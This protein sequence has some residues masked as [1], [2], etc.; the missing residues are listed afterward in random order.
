MRSVHDRQERREAFNRENPVKPHPPAIDLTVV[1]RAPGARPH[2]V[3]RDASGR[4]QLSVIPDHSEWLANPHATGERFSA[5]QEFGLGELV[6]RSPAQG[7][8]TM[9][10]YE[11]G[12]AHVHSRGVRIWRR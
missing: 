5:R 2:L 9:L 8:G 6:K 3:L 12:Y 1:E 10:H 4:S 11:R 7:G